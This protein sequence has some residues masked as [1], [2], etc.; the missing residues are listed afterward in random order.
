MSLDRINA[1]GNYEPGNV[2]W[3]SYAVQ[4]ANRRRAAWLGDHHWLAILA[5]LTESGSPEGLAAYAALSAQFKGP[6]AAEG[7]DLEL[8]PGA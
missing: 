8:S 5:A 2:R 1:D 4:V 3:A 7:F 6:L